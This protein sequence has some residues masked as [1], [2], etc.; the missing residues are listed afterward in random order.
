MAVRTQAQYDTLKK[1]VYRTVTGTGLAATALV[2]YKV[3]TSDTANVSKI[4]NCKNTVSVTDRMHCAW[5]S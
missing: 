5:Q 2:G 1:Q 3:V 4:N